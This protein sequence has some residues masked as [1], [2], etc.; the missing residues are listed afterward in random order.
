MHGFTSLVCLNLLNHNFL[1][2]KIEAEPEKKVTQ[3][4]R[5]FGLLPSPPASYPSSVFGMM[6]F[7]R[8]LV[9]F[10]Y[11]P[12]WWII[13]SEVSPRP[14]VPLWLSAQENQPLC[15]KALTFLTLSP[16]RVCQ[17]EAYSH[18]DWRLRR[19][20][21]CKLPGALNGVMAGTWT[22]N[23]HVPYPPKASSWSSPWKLSCSINNCLYGLD[24]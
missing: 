10:T 13:P 11:V 7:F 1:K 3:K 8:E 5:V 4:A 15:T 23:L 21:R 16:S 9:P 18:Q 24:S 2:Q 14:R 19:L 22:R 6:F 12:G 20:P 17:P